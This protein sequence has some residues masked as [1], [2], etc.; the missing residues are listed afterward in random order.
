[1]AKKKDSSAADDLIRSLLD[2]IS[3]EDPSRVSSEETMSPPMGLE[4]PKR[5]DEPDVGEESQFKGPSVGSGR[6]QSPAEIFGE[7][8]PPTEPVGEPVSSEKSGETVILP[9]DDKTIPLNAMKEKPVAASPLTRR[10][11]SEDSDKVVYNKPKAGS[12]SVMIQVDA[13]LVQ[14]ES[15]RMAQQRILELEKE[16]DHLREDNEEVSSAADIIKNR[17]DEMRSRLLELE[18]A[19]DEAVD[20]ARGEIMIL[21][22]QL[23]FKENELGKAQ[24]KIEELEIRLKNDFKKVRVRERDLENRLE[25]MKAEKTAL[26]RAKDDN[27]LEM[28]RKT[29][30]LQS[31]IDNYRDKC[32]ELNKILENQK[33]QFKRTTRAL[34]LALANLEVRDDEVIPLKKA[35]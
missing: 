16:V 35:E 7:E 8:P 14:A 24:N 2:D 25:L 11:L 9:V 22:G 34:K 1:M 32:L 33:E 26:V 27:I 3:S 13:S 17:A 6:Y 5:E 23:Q 21:K 19:R 10:P 29:D 15:L 18:K 4:V 12:P 20:S 28:K 30:Q 31:E